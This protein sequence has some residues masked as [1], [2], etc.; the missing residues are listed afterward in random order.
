MDW[1][2]KFE[3][4]GTDSGKTG[5]VYRADSDTDYHPAAMRLRGRWNHAHTVRVGRNG[6]SGGN[7]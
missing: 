6:Y 1:G 2:G 5:D 3:Q 4:I 7:A